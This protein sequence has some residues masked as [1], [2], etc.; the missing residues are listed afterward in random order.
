M[1][2]PQSYHFAYLRGKRTCQRIDSDDARE[3]RGRT[4]IFFSPSPGMRAVVILESYR[5][6]IPRDFPPG[7][8]SSPYPSHT[9]E[10]DHAHRSLICALLRELGSLSVTLSHNYR[11]RA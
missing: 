3:R 4:N 1:N 10:D 6:R 2:L 9:P 8:T 11:F 5:L 7:K